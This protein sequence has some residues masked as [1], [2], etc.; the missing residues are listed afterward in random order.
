[1]V[2]CEME[3]ERVKMPGSGSFPRWIL[4]ANILQ[5]PCISFVQRLWGKVEEFEGQGAAGDRACWKFHQFKAI[6]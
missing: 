5:F 2:H 1:M 6:K 3:R 4:F